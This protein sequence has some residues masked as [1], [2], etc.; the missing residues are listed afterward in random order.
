MSRYQ[1]LV[2][3]RMSMAR[4]LVTGFEPFGSHERN[5]SQDVVESLPKQLECIDPW[6]DLR[7]HSEVPI[8]I[9][10]ETKVL[11]VDATGSVEIAHRL[12]NG[13]HWDAI[14]HIGQCD[15]CSIPRF[16]T[17]AQDRLAMRIPDNDGR[18]IVDSPLTG[19]GDV[20]SSAPLK[21][22]QNIDWKAEWELSEDSG[23][24]LCNET[25][26]RT[27]STL[28]S[29]DSQSGSSIPCFFLHLPG[30]DQYSV[31]D[32]TALVEDILERMMYRPV[33]NVVCALITNEDSYLVAQ[34]IP[35]AVH[36][37]KWEFPGG[38]VEPGES[39][40]TAIVREIGEEFGWI[41]EAHQSI[42]TF[43]HSLSHTDIA[44]HAIPCTRVDTSPVFEDSQHWTSHQ[45]I[46]W[47]N[48][49]DDSP[50]DWLGNDE[51]IV[52]WMRKTGYLVKS[53]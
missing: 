2:N 47:R 7:Q 1:K 51:A 14:L 16:E 45:S 43:F 44:L 36:G 22:W 53:T 5:I 42:G 40:Q 13:E 17:R 32:G 10:I 41:V 21:A 25:M 3:L 31:E 4:V 27:L 28:Q 39:K 48:I 23:T 18:R 38:K 19:N 46:Q 29:P 35:D 34:R 24:F 37:A 33:L 49:L 30:P 52:A 12:L 26:Y 11:S 15:S 9:Q 20:W 50:L 6:Q 8:N